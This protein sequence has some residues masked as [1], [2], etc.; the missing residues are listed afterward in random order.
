MSQIGQ[1]TILPSSFTGGPRHM[2]QLFQDAMAC[3]RVPGKPD[4]FVTFTA[5][6]K[7]PEIISELD[8]G[9]DPNDRPD[10]ISRVSR[11]KL[12]ALL[13]DI[14][15]SQIFGKIIANIYVI[16]W[17]KRGLPHAHILLCL[18]AAAKI[19]IVNQV[20]NLVNAE[21]PD[22]TKHKL[23][24]ETVSSSMMHGPCG[25]GYPNAPCMKEGRCSKGFPKEFREETILA[26]DK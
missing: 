20:D 24:F 19:V 5:N 10:L 9:Q 12:K 8:K 13:N 15:E 17:Q 2:N 23:V 16:E 4:L 18:E 11:L 7:W 22:K 6:P 21:I 25:L 14:L 3:I 1:H 26:K